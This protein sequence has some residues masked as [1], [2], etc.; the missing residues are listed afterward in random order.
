MAKAKPKKA[1]KPKAKAK[2]KPKAKPK[3][4]A[5]PKGKSKPRPKAKRETPPPA[6]QAPVPAP[7]VALGKP[8]IVKA[9]DPG[10]GAGIESGF[11]IESSTSFPADCTVIAVTDEDT[12]ASWS[13]V[14]VSFAGDSNKILCVGIASTTASHAARASGTL[15]VTLSNPPAGV[16]SPVAVPVD[17]VDDLP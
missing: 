12:S 7:P 15:H 6:A 1:A 13:V 10:S 16:T 11:A 3:A 9:T 14:G 2:G 4:K 8:L 17:Y 5:K